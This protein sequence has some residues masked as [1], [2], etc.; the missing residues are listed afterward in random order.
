MATRKQSRKPAAFSLRWRSL[1]PRSFP[2]TIFFVLDHLILLQS[3]GTACGVAAGLHDAEVGAIPR[4]V[5][6]FESRVRLAARFVSFRRRRPYPLLG[7]A[8][9]VEPAS[10]S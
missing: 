6:G 10:P 1:E 2:R 5:D 7:M 3:C 9:G 4:A 8:G